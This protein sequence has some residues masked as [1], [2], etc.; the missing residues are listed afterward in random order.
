MSLGDT[1]VEALFGNLGNRVPLRRLTFAA[2]GSRRR[3]NKSNRASASALACW[4]PRE[5]EAGQTGK[6]LKRIKETGD[7]FFAESDRDWI[8]AGANV[9]VSMIGF[10]AGAESRRLLDGKPVE[11]INPNL[12]AQNDTT[13]A[14]TLLRN[15]NL[16]LRASEKGGDFVLNDAEALRFLCATNPNGK[17][18]SDVIRP[19]TNS[20]LLLGGAPHKWIVDFFGLTAEELAARY[21][22]PFE[23]LRMHVKPERQGNRDAR[24]VKYW[25]LHR[26]SAEDMREATKGHT[27]FIVT[28]SVAKHRTFVW[29]LHPLLPDHQLYVFSNS[30]D[31]FLGHTPFTSP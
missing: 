6:C 22:A 27:R 21:E 11:R 29:V 5:F 4:L 31:S 18:N 23:H 3:A 30:T 10:D 25:W 2:T 19:W 24:L 7:I 20:E 17:P 15:Q 8:L 9:H 14:L 28:P 13:R 12:T 16:C 26:R 1:Y